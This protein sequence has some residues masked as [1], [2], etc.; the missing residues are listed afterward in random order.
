[1]TTALDG[2]EYEAAITE[3][4][5]TARRLGITGTPTFVFDNRFAAVGAQ[6]AEALLQAIERALH[7]ALD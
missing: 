7:D 1:M 6:P 4:T 5:E 2:G 3:T